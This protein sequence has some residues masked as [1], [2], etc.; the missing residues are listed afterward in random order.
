MRQFDNW[1]H[2]K[3]I[4]KQTIVYRC[5]VLFFFH[6]LI[7]CV[8]TAVTTSVISCKFKCP[9]ETFISR[10]RRV[11][12]LIDVT[13]VY[14]MFFFVMNLC[15]FSTPSKRISIPFTFSLIPFHF[16]LIELQ[17]PCCEIYSF[18]ILNNFVG[19]TPENLCLTAKKHL[20]WWVGVLLSVCNNNII[21][22]I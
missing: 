10:A 3:I 14:A 13:N 7:F 1:K 8:F 2:F 17:V 20:S 19:V 22:R 9:I 5:S 15:V 4:L 16:I 6:Y 21:G 11:L 12:F 18:F